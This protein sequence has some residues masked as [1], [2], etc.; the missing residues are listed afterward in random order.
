V[1]T[2]QALTAANYDAFCVTAPTDD[3]LGETSGQ[4]ICGLYDRQPASFGVTSEVIELASNYGDSTEVYD[5]MDIGVTGRYGRGGILQ[6]GVSFGRLTQ[7]NCD[8]L[9]KGGPTVGSNPSLNGDPTAF[10]HTSNTNQTQF[11]AAGN[12]PLPWWGIETSLTY[13]NNPGIDYSSTRSY[14]RNEIGQFGANRTLEDSSRTVT[15]MK[16]FTQH[17]DRINQVDVRIGKRWQLGRARIRGQFDIYN[18]TNSSA[19][20][21]RLSNYG[22]DGARFQEVSNVLGARL[23]KFGVQFEY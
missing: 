12:Y 10:C 13:Q 2:N 22:T 5:G 6:G 21:A 7:D 20:L 8:M 3:R 15:I 11:K 9:A 17:G 16:P 14:S 23:F 18:V 4:Q 1:T 19:I